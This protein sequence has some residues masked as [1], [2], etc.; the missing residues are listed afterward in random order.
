MYQAVILDVDGTL[1]DSNDAHARA[2]VDAFAESGRRVPF[3]RVRPHIG[4]G[5]DKL[6]PAAIGIDLESEE[7]RALAARRREIF[8]RRYL[9]AVKPTRGASELLNWFRDE[10]LKLVVASSAEEEELRDLLRIA[11]ATRL[12]EGAASRD[13]APQSKPDPDI[14]R[15]ALARTGC[16]PQEVM[17]LGDTPYDVEASLRSG[18]GIVA[19]R[20]GGWNDDALRGAVAIYDDPEDLLDHYPLSP[21]KRP[22]PV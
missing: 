4:M 10:R 2:W 14:V 22:L 9:D 21:F 13:E 8:Q 1:V 20:C 16:P 12:V 3:E 18:I 17:M 5:S 6:L 19:L 15:A 11:G 7:G